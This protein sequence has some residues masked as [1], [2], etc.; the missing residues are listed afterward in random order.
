VYRTDGHPGRA[1]GEERDRV[2]AQARRHARPARHRQKP[3]PRDDR[4]ARADA[5]AKLDNP[6]KP[7]G[8]FML[9]GPSGVGKTET[10]L[11]LAESL[12]G[13]EQNVDHDQYER[14]QEAHTVSTLKGAPPGYVGYGEEASSPRRCAAVLTALCCSTRWKRRTPTAR[15]LFPGVR[16]GLDGG[17]R[18]RYIDF[19]NTIILLTSTRGSDLIMNMCKDPELMPE[20]EGSLRPCASRFSRSSPAA[21]PRTVV[22][23][24]YYP[25]SDAM[26]SNIIRLQIGRIKKRIED[27]PSRELQLHR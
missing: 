1:N 27:K 20:A 14:Y 22:V 10:A 7:V 5:R 15:D 12:Y 2:G 16:Q 25:L 11:A 23:I 3:R 26:L 6:N 17:R 13:G 19:K 9:C 18:G 8:V 4:K 21:A 24:P